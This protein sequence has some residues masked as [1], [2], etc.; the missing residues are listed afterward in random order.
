MQANIEFVLQKYLTLETMHTTKKISLIFKSYSEF[1]GLTV[2][3]KNFLP[4]DWNTFI[5]KSWSQTWNFTVPRTQSLFQ[6]FCTIFQDIGWNLNSI[7]KLPLA[8]I[9]PTA[10]SDIILG[11]I[12]DFGEG[13]MVMPNMTFFWPLSS[14]NV[15]WKKITS[16]LGYN[17]FEGY[18]VWMASI[19]SFWKIS[20]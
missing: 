11:R 2:R 18:R 5:R 9:S 7:A 13:A 17:S 10:S 19:C 16:F 14:Q 12:D 4:V 8:M 1:A 6:S 3:I 15:S 20:S